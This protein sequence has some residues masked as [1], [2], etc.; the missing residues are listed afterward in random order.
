[1]TLSELPENGFHAGPVT[2]DDSQRS[3]PTGLGHRSKLVPDAKR[4][5]PDKSRRWPLQRLE[6]TRRVR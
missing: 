5:T 1:M 4:G 3:Q 2:A 6:A